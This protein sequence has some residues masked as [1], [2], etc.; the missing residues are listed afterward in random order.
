MQLLTSRAQSIKKLFLRTTL[1]I[2]LF[3]ASAC[4]DSND[5]VTDPDAETTT[6]TG[7]VDS[8]T[9]DAGTAD[10][11][12]VI[13][14]GKPDQIS[15]PGVRYVTCPFE[16][17]PA[18]EGFRCGELDTY[19]NYE[20]TG[21]DA[22]VIQVAFGIMPAQTKPAAADPVVVFIG[23]P[24]ASALLDVA[25]FGD[26]WPFAEN[27]DVIL[28]DQRGVGFSTPF[29][30]CDLPGL[31]GNGDVDVSATKLC[32]DEF[33]Q[34]G[35]DLTQYRSQV[36][37]Q[38]FKVLREAMEIEQWNVYGES[39]GPIPGIL[40]AQLDPS[41]VRSVIFD[42]STDN[43][44]DI[45]LAD[46]ASPFNYFTELSKQCAGE[47]ECSSRLPDLRSTILDTYSSLNNEPWL[48]QIGDSMETFDGLAFLS[49]ILDARG[50]APAL[51]EL[52]ATR[53]AELLNELI[54]LGDNQNAQYSR[55]NPINVRQVLTMAE[56]EN[57]EFAD[58]MHASVQCAAIDAKNFAD[59]VV[60]TIEQWPDELIDVAKQIVFYP[61]IC[62]SD[63]FSIEPDPT[64]RNPISLDVPALILGG[65]LDTVVSLVEVQKLSESFTSPNLAIVPKAGHGV[66]GPGTDGC[67]A[68]IVSSFIE[69]PTVA[70][71]TTCLPS[72]V[73]PF[74]FDQAL[75]DTF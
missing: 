52:Y 42:S 26:I 54:E 55:E 34:Q 12:A 56:L 1:L 62:T 61:K 49:I 13:Q 66:F 9:A 35:V 50:F 36:I 51:V 5:N 65:G 29:L 75:I 63:V 47:A 33:E 31:R 21:E 15:A 19:E 41:G 60:P 46:T 39:Y 8:G 32:V 11:G 58:L 25:I 28:V 69:E 73:E 44:V 72:T 43:Q 53:N 40:Y 38:D 74:P 70:T 57:K 24:G 3:A 22:R 23:G 67:V 37:A 30:N 16:L 45:A 71:D 68:D 18:V 17:L 59:A 64:Q 48:V 4:S 6:T 14:D 27:R 20:S 10:S 2:P 7:T